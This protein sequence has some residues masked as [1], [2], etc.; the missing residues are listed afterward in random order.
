V[1]NVSS[2]SRELLIRTN[3]SFEKFYKKMRKSEISDNTSL[4]LNLPASKTDEEKI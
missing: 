4:N 1:G 3:R 2:H